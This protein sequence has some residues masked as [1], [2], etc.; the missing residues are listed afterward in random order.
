M[1]TLF[2]KKHTVKEKAVKFVGVNLPLPLNSYLT[3]YSIAM[4]TSKSP[5]ICNQIE[6]WKEIQEELMPIEELIDL[7]VEKAMEECPEKDKRI[8]G[9][10]LYFLKRLKKELVQKG[11]EDEVIRKILKKVR[12]EANK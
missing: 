7:V 12:H 2:S 4:S 11:I 5:L 3:L 10:L 6:E 9:A 8:E 1:G